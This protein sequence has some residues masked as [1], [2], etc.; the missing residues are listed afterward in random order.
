ML[1]DITWC[2]DHPQRG[3]NEHVMEALKENHSLELSDLVSRLLNTDPD[4]RPT[5][6][7]LMDH[8]FLI[9]Q[10]Q[11]VHKEKQSDMRMLFPHDLLKSIDSVHAKK[12][13]PMM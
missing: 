12:L 9:R 10:L 8:P 3:S 11:I 2:C 1:F 7:E 6:D 4:K 13:G 5:A